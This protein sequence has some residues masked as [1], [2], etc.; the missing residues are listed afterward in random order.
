VMRWLDDLEDALREQNF[1]LARRLAQKILRHVP[2]QSGPGKEALGHLGMALAMLDEYEAS[3]QTLSEALALQPERSDLWYNRSLSATFTVRTGQS[4]LDLEQA[5]ALEQD[6]SLLATYNERL[7]FMRHIVAEEL[8]LRGP[9]FTLEQLI[10]Q[11]Q[12]FN[13]ALALFQAKRY[14]DAEAA[15]KRV[16]EIA[17]VLPQPWANLAGCYMWQERYDEAEAALRR[18]LEIDPDYPLAQENL[19]YLPTVRQYGLAALKTSIK[20]AFA[21]GQISRSVIFTE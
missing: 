19:L 21:E 8:A 13:H 16:I 11:Q 14:V 7:D 15:F 20:P 9:D 2:V 4:L 5:V 10:E 3:Y 18:A 6:S 12:L 17:D 1:K